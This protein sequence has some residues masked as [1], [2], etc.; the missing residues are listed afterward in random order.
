MSSCYQ[1]NKVLLTNF[2]HPKIF[3]KLYANMMNLFGRS[4]LGRRSSG[5]SS[6]DSSARRS[7]VE[8]SES[9][10]RDAATRTCLWPC[11]E[12]MMRVVLKRNLSNM[13]TMPVS[14]PTFQI[15]VNN[16]TFSLNHLSKDLNSFPVSL[17]CSLCFMITHIPY[18]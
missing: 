3:R 8:P 6:S 13:F 2:C 1:F 11:D 15:S 18:H 7:Y 4:S 10:T 14:I 9:S 5:A 16:A 17:G 12:Y